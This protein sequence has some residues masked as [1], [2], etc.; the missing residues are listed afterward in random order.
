MKSAPALKTVVAIILRILALEFAVFIL[1]E[2]PVG[3]TVMNHA[4]DKCPYG[5]SWGRTD[6]A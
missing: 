3:V 1:E 6:E 2:L 4:P 5:I